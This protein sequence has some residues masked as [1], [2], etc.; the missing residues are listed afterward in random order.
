MPSI[1]AAH[2]CRLAVQE[3]GQRPRWVLERHGG[4]FLP[5]GLRPRKQ[6]WVF[7]LLRPPFVGDIRL[8]L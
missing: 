2:S 6:R 5:H 3:H 1:R 8:S 7:E 4:G